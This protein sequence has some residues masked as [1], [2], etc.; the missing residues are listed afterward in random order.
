MLKLEEEAVPKLHDRY[1]QIQAADQVSVTMTEARR[2]RVCGIRFP[3]HPGRL[4]RR[5]GGG[6]DA[7]TYPMPNLTLHKK[8]RKR[9][10]SILP[11]QMTGWLAPQPLPAALTP[12]V[13]YSPIQLWLTCGSPMLRLA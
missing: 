3:C 8:R 1:L 12:P 13:E 5:K 2:E 6:S 4:A 7:F 9:M 11:R 10:T